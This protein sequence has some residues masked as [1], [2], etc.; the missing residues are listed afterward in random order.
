MEH[1][2]HCH[3]S[4]YNRENINNIN[5]ISSLPVTLRIGKDLLLQ[6]LYEN[7]EDILSHLASPRQRFEE[8]TLNKFQ[9]KEIWEFNVKATM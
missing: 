6:T 4:T 5:M 2:N 9:I 7:V 8:S 3:Q 1:L